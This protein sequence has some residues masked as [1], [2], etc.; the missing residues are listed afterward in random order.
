MKNNP[1]LSKLSADVTSR[2]SSTLFKAGQISAGEYNR[3]LADC[4]MLEKQARQVMAIY[5]PMRREQPG[6]SYDS[7][8][9]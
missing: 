4:R 3:I 8:K 9:F 7:R 2:E 5:A 1:I 6:G